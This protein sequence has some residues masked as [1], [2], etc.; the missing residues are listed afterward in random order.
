MTKLRRY[1]T[2]RLFHRTSVFDGIG[3]VINIAGNYFDFNYSNSGEEADR[4]AIEND[5]GVIGDDILEA[6]KKTNDELLQLQ[7]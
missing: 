2:N 4:K 6:A 1:K 3:S 7:D 5:W